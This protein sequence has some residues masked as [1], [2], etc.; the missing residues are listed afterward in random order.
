[1][2]IVI[3]KERSKA[4]CRSCSSRIYHCN[5]SPELDDKACSEYI[6][7]YYDHM[8]IDIEED[9]CA[10]LEFQKWQYHIEYLVNIKGNI[11]HRSFFEIHADLN[12]ESD[13]I[14]KA[15]AE[16][17]NQSEAEMFLQVLD[18]IEGLKEKGW[19]K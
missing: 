19:I 4:T 13:N 7:P 14:S 2:S 5:K 11:A 17:C 6:P 10:V 15:L 1:M 9:Q 12:Q 3:E 8:I 18:A 16:K